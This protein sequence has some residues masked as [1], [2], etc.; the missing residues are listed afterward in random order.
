[1]NG[2]QRLLPG[3]FDKFLEWH[4]QGFKII[5][6]T[7]RPE[8]LRE[9]T[10]RQLRELGVFYNQLVMDCGP[11]PRVLINDMDSKIDDTK[12]RAKAQAVNLI[13]DNGMEELEINYTQEKDEAAE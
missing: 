6:T 2:T 11:G 8:F 5:L 4:R 12:F 1:M 9:E 10:E 3:V 13:R 7:G